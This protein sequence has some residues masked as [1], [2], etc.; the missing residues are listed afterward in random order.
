MTERDTRVVVT[1]DETL[2]TVI[3][4]LREAASGGR[5][6][7][8]VVPIDSALFLTAKEFRSLKD[9]I[10]D[11][12]LSVVMRT[13]DPLRLQ[14]GERLGVSAKAPPR[15][16]AKALAPAPPAPSPAPL[17]SPAGS[18]ENG[19]NDVAESS[20]FARPD[21]ALRWPTQ[22]GAEPPATLLEEVEPD[23]LEPRPKPASTNPP[24]RWVPVAA[25]L[26]ALV[27]ATFLTIRFVVPHAV[28]RIVPK[29]APVE[30][31]LVFDVTNDG[32]PLDGEAAF[33]LKPQVRELQ[34]VWDGRLPTTGVRL[35]PDGVATGSIELRNASATPLTVDAGTIVATETGVEY[36]F[37]QAVTVPATDAATGKP[38]AASGTVKAIQPGSESNVG[39]GELGGRLPNG[40]YYSNRMAPTNGGT[41]KKYPVVAQADLDALSAQANGAAPELAAKALATQGFTG[42]AILSPV[43]VSKQQDSFDHQIN[44]DADSVSLRATLTVEATTYETGD[45]EAKYKQALAA[46]LADE[47]PAGYRIDSEHIDFAA[48]AEAKGEADGARLE[49]KAHA[50]ARAVLDDQEWQALASKLA[51]HNAEEAAAILAQA[52]EI[53]TYT[54]E[55]QPA[56]LPKEMP[57]NADRI[58]LELAK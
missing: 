25:L 38:G 37:T 46:K 21:P 11:Q 13:S 19:Q 44:D 24:R 35:V 36:A 45:A 39:T 42:E 50:D 41:D 43:S 1:S 28:V 33:A 3:D 51:G 7:D 52:P 49:V 12:R 54:V 58:Q 23:Q 18:D 14:L 16:R 4:R 2:P 57:N 30:A 34:V 20:P 22:N 15:P 6:V 27:L 10:D 32:R 47:A 26:A 31:S 48:P 9:A 56:W 5:T 55:Y 53:A 40:L 29:T 17:G 8:L